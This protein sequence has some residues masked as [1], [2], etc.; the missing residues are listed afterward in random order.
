MQKLD[1]KNLSLIDKN[2]IEYLR[3]KYPPIVYRND[4]TTDQFINDS[5][6]R[7]GQIDLIEKIESIYKTQ[8]RSK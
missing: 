1:Q 3:Q 4:Q 5:I 6:F 2:L 7:A 8:N